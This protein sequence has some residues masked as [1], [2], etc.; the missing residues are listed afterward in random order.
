VE[1]VENTKKDT[2]RD[3]RW[4][5][6]R[7]NVIG[8]ALDVPG[9]GGLR[10]TGPLPVGASTYLASS[11]RRQNLVRIQRGCSLCRAAVRDLRKL[12]WPAMEPS[13][14]DL[15][16]TV[17]VTPLGALDLTSRDAAEAISRF[18]GRIRG[19]LTYPGWRGRSPCSGAV[20]SHQLR[21]FLFRGGI[22]AFSIVELYVRHWPPWRCRRKQQEQTWWMCRDETRGMRR[23]KEGEGVRCWGEVDFQVGRG[24]Q[25]TGRVWS[26]DWLLLGCRESPPVKGALGK[27]DRRRTGE[28]SSLPE[29]WDDVEG[30]RVALGILQNWGFRRNWCILDVLS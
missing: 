22:V 25:S 17:K 9:S 10:W 26:R 16:L 11:C 7:K 3:A 5:H 28:A 23:G 27:Q 1:V 20:G 29:E 2:R 12:T 6:D 4:P 15:P 30:E 21:E 18:S 14:E 8:R 24:F 19:L 13:W